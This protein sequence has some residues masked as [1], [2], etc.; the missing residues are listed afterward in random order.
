MADQAFGAEEYSIGEH[1]ILSSTLNDFDLGAGLRDYDESEHNPFVYALQA[2]SKR[3]D[4]VAV[5]ERFDR[6]D[7]T[8]HVCPEDALALAGGDANL[9]DSILRGCVVLHKMP[10][11]LLAA[12]ATEPRVAWL[13]EQEQ[14]YQ[15][16]LYSSLGMPLEPL[17]SDAPR[18]EGGPQ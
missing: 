2:E 10:S 3:L 8:F 13:R 15:A 12:D 1:D 11:D 5:I 14:A 16:V 17:C 18:K 4:G 9:A 6:H 7:A